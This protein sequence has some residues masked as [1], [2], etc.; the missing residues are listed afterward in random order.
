MREERREREGGCF[1]PLVSGAVAGGAHS[2]G[3]AGHPGALPRLLPLRLS[4]SSS[5][6]LSGSA[7]SSCDQGPYIVQDFLIPLDFKSDFGNHVTPTLH[8]ANEENK[9]SMRKTIPAADKARGRACAG[10]CVC[11]R[12]I[13]GSVSYARVDRESNGGSLRNHRRG[14]GE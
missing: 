4:L 1:Q 10:V 6:S 8:F 11:A 12:I 3:R 14:P 13:L 7:S 5:R 2:R 9:P